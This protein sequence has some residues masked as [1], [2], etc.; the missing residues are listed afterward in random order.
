MSTEAF[1][2]GELGRQSAYVDTYTPSLLNSIPREVT[3]REAGINADA[4][5]GEDVWTAYEFSWVNTQGK[6]IS[7][8]LRLRVACQSRTIIESKSLKLYLMS[9]ANTKFA[10]RAD[11]LKTLDQDLAVGFRAPVMV[12]LLDIAHMESTTGQMPGR[13]LDEQDVRCTVYQKD[14]NLLVPAES[15][16]HVREAVYTHL[17]RT[18]CPV[19]GQ[20]D[21]ASVAIEYSGPPIDEAGLLK[22]LVSYRNHPGFHETAIET[23]FCDLRAAYELQSLSVYG[24]FQRRGGLDINPFRSTVETSAPIYRIARQ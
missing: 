21:C 2:A 23:I 20:P 7:C 15:E 8:G 22:Y 6:P 9:F 14:G 17:F 19:T 5:V 24:R 1:D 12:E 3:R 13:C 4:L 10:S 11:V 16:T 18:L